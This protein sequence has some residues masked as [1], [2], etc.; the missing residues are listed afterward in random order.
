MEMQ[1][2]ARVLQVVRRNPVG[3]KHRMVSDLLAALRDDPSV[4]V[5]VALTPDRNYE[6]DFSFGGALVHIHEVRGSTWGRIFRLAALA[7][8]YDIIHLHGFA[9]WEALAVI[10]SGT[11]IV[12]TNHGLLGTGRRLS[13]RE[14]I[15]QGLAR[16]FLRYKVDRIVNVSS[17]ALHRLV[18]AYGVPVGKN[19]VVYNCTRWE[20]SRPRFSWKGT[21]RI[22]F[23]GRFVAFKR[24]DRLI[25]V[26]A[27]VAKKLDVVVCLV[28]EGPMRED[29]LRRAKA[30][31]LKLE[32]HDYVSDVR[33]I[34]ESFGVEIVP[35][36]EEYFGLAVLESIQT[37]HATFVFRDSG[38]CA[39]IF[40]ASTGW[41]VCSN[42]QEMA[43]KILSMLEGKQCLAALDRL[44][45][46]QE[47]I[48]TTFSMQVFGRA[49]S[50]LYADAVLR[51]GK[52]PH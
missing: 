52:H 21:I 37:G 30:R 16:L 33:K 19:L 5:E 3:G 50:G 1:T 49:Y 4:H 29:I 2:V 11:F 31:G 36:D 47:R 14:H 12:Y 40:D 38:G 7:R 17:F 8:N 35:S 39:E 22:G 10:L 41:F 20:A 15:K 42:E 23:H 26:A 25:E 46:L 28:G 13:T 27:Q 51:G 43:E 18:E 6:G 44:T 48:T 34:V 9:P 24:L 32:M 45:N